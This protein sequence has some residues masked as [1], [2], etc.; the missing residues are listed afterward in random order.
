V[1]AE[2]AAQA[3][4]PLPLRPSRLRRLIGS[5]Y[6]LIRNSLAAGMLL[7]LVLVT[8]PITERLYKGLLVTG[9]P[10]EAD[11][12]VCLGGRHERLLWT[13]ECYDRGLAPR[14][15]VSN[16]PGAAQHMKKMLVHCGLPAERVLVDDKSFTTVD[17]P[18]GIAAL[19]GMDPAGQRFLIVTDHEHSRRVAALFRRAG[20]EDFTI[21]G[22]PPGLREGDEAQVRWRW[23]IM[24]LPRIAYEYAALIQ[25]RLQGRI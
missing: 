2:N 10:Q 16:A 25:Y 5:V 20:Y 11:V 15:V 17:H 12:V 23:R 7:L 14:V 24:Y 18:P 4:V 9:P 1:P 22:G 8:T 13:A 3:S 6:R 21:Y 19:P